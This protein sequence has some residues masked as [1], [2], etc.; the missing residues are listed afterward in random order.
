MPAS[1]LDSTELF[2]LLGKFEIF[3]GFKEYKVHG[4]EVRM[5]EK[6]SDLRARYLNLI[7]LNPSKADLAKIGVWYKDVRLNPLSTVQTAKLKPGSVAHSLAGVVVSHEPAFS[8]LRVP[9]MINA[10]AED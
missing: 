8:P 7:K 6:M 9:C 2:F 5:T 1:L 3:V 4:I 10:K